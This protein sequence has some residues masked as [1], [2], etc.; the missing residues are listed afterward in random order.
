MPLIT[1]H[2]LRAVAFGLLALTHSIPILIVGVVLFGLS[3]F[4]IIPL[5]TGVIADRFGANAMGGILGSSWLIHQVSAGAGVLL[6]GLLRQFSG[7]YALSFASGAAVLVVSAVLA[8][9][10]REESSLK[11]TSTVVISPSPA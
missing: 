5:T 8:T 6:G 11:P 9:L 2:L 4:P 10:I 1:L 7:T 3:S